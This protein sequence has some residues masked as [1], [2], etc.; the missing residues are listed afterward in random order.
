MTL[1][2][3]RINVVIADDHPV[4]RMGLRQVI[5]HD[6]RIR[7]LA[8][9]ENG[10]QAMEAIF[11]HQPHVAVLDIE[12]PE[13]SGIDVMRRL[14][15]EDCQTR[16][17]VLTIHDNETIFESVVELGALG[18]ILKDSAMTDIL[19]AIH[20]VAAGEYHI[21][22]TLPSNSRTGSVLLDELQSRLAVLTPSE[23][24]VLDL[25]ARNHS[26]ADIAERL[27]VSPRTVTHHRENI[28]AKLDL[29]G[30]HALL[31][32][33]LENQTLITQQSAEL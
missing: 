11:L 6:P 27:H 12:M 16:I 10:R 15:K 33:A 3:Q 8:E 2:G 18:Y 21:S 22:P 32:F 7:I 24:R 20:R 31:R 1:N 19:R 17:I 23:R 29:H 9:A 28:C 4:V 14:R 26:S 5:G 13:M 25:I 30:S